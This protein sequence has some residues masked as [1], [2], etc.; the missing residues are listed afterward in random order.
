VSNGNADL[1]ARLRLEADV[2]DAINDINRTDAAIKGTGA[3]SATA[4][5]ALDKVAASTTAVAAASTKATAG[6]QGQAA[7]TG[8]AAVA[9]KALDAANA[10]GVASMGSTAKGASEVAKAAGGAAA[11][12][13]VARAAGGALL[14]LVGGPLGIGLM[15]GAAVMSVFKAGIDAVG[16]AN[17]RIKAGL[18]TTVDVLEEL[19][20]QSETMADETVALSI[21][22]GDAAG[23]A[24]VTTA[25]YD[26]QSAAAAGA[27]RSIRDMTLAQKLQELEKVDS[28]LSD[29]K[30]SNRTTGLLGL[31]TTDGTEKAA[32]ARQKLLEGLYGSETQRQ[33]SG[34][35]DAELVAEA[36]ANYSKL[37]GKDR[38][39][40]DDFNVK[41]DTFQVKVA[42]IADREARKAALLKDINLPPAETPALLDEVVVTAARNKKGS[43]DRQG[44]NAGV[45]AK[46]AAA[47]VAAEKERTKA[48]L[49][50]S[51]AM[52]AYRISEA[53][54]QAVEKV[55]LADKPKLTAAET[56]LVAS[57]RSRAEETERLR[58]ANERIEKAGGLTKAAE[59]DTV[60]LK[61]RAVAVGQGEQA[62]E[63]LEVKEAGL[64][65]LQRLGVDT[66]ADLSGEALTY[67]QAAI[68]AAEATERQAIATDKATRVAG[69]TKD[70]DKRI[71]SEKALAAAQAG[72]VQAMVEYT[73]AE[74]IRQALDQAGTN[75]TND[76][77]A[78]ITAKVRALYAVAAAADEAG[79]VASETEELRLTRLTNDQR[80][81]EERVLQRIGLLKAQHLDWTR[82][83]VEARARALAL[84]DQA[85][86]R[87]ARAI[88]DLKQNLEDA[89]VEA[90]ELGMD[91]V[92][93]YAERALRKA[94]FDAW[95]A[96]P[97]DIIVNAV[98]G[99][100]S[101]LTGSIGTAGSV[102]GVAGLASM[103]N[104]AGGLAG[105]ASGS[106]KAIT[107]LLNKT[108]MSTWNAAKFGGMAGG[109]IGGAGT[110]MLVSGL[111]SALGLKQTKGNQIGGTIGGAVGSF[112]PIP[113]GA[114]IGAALGNLVGGL[115][116]GKKSNEAAV[117]DLNAA[118]QVTSIGGAKRNDA[119]TA[120]AQQIAEATAQ[121]QAAL[122]AAGATLNATISKIDIGQRDATH[123]N[124]SNG[125]AM[126]TAVGD[127]NAA[128]EA[129]TKTIIANAK[130]ATQAQTD[131]A[132]KMLAAGASLNEVIAQLGAASGFSTSIDDAIAQL[133]DPAAYER[134]AALAAIEANY[135]ALK[136]QAEELL[137]AGLIAGDV[138]GQLAKLRDL[139]VADSIARLGDAAKDAADKLAAD[140]SA[141][142]SLTGSISDEILAILDP[143][144]GR[145][146]TALD[147]IERDYQARLAEANRLI[148]AGVLGGEVIG[149][150]ETLK[151]LQI[152]QVLRELTGVAAE[153]TDAFGEA[154]PRLQSWLDGLSASNDNQLNPAEE[155]K[156]AQAQYDKQLA[157]ARA[158]DAGAL[159]SIT[160]YA[161][162]LLAADRNATSSATDRLA[163]FNRVTGDVSG[164]VGRS[165]GGDPVAATLQ[166]LGVTLGA[167]NTSLNP[168][169]GGLTGSLSA[170]LVAAPFRIG[171][172][173]DFGPVLTLAAGP[174]T[175]R[176]V[177]SIDRM[178]AQVTAALAVLQASS[179]EGFKALE[180]ALQS[181][182][183]AV[184]SAVGD[185]RSAT[186]QQA[187]QLSAMADEQRLNAV[188]QRQKWVA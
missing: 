32:K 83:E 120:A 177:A 105:L 113:G 129:A 49:A 27:A 153:A 168:A 90:G 99:S 72:G 36:R 127:V 133:T 179:S 116:G 139:E 119:T 103:F 167:L 38:A 52:D 25:A 163:T 185:V 174:Q 69:V 184:E 37:A 121:V 148:A 16:E 24:D 131:Y 140:T 1:T 142:G 30:A 112:I 56:V 9:A 53:G 183:N 51:A 45:A 89:F 100:I 82:E 2:D 169:G 102:G 176:L 152:D 97:I 40:L 115:V 59:A 75:L 165:G 161:D 159:G 19:R 50:G 77:V 88:G 15:A 55:G 136:A 144:A 31:V 4:A 145:K 62:I 67:A 65:V 86:A 23:A 175:D 147:K 14:S 122:V 10:G 43:T 107:G 164:L 132:Q 101:G 170:A 6:L 166:S 146:K 138:L 76:Q 34:R 106:A 35:S 66:L 63:D 64:Q 123:L 128:I 41:D 130:W 156:L 117:L 87:D 70:L 124:F 149:Q 118:G 21:A 178:G 73:L 111:A 186:D 47:D 92:A 11:S 29:L 141:A 78:A 109:A 96:K 171:N 22:M 182:L 143:A 61:A 46:D 57:I 95:L 12:F 44:F 7:A 91:E 26:R 187:Q 162:Q 157:M 74:R 158:G 71:A 108:S 135:Q 13:G 160:S 104:S 84:V 188:F 180:D 173:P 114:L 20:Q 42:A 181:G 17:E 126:D 150:L 85:A 94:I 134:K 60:A 48:I 33:F 18:A 80:E 154:R 54:R 3:A 155:L 81:L 98:V 8:Q 93:D 110:G 5:P 58:I 79:L 151:G 137:A 39:N 172:I 68:T 125:Q 28:Q